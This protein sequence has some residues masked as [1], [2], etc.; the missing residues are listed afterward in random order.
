MFLDTERWHDKRGA[1]QAQPDRNFS[2]E[3]AAALWIEEQTRLKALQSE[4]CRVLP[5]SANVYVSHTAILHLIDSPVTDFPRSL[6][7]SRLHTL[8]RRRGEEGERISRG[9]HVAPPRLE[10]SITCRVLGGYPCGDAQSPPSP[11]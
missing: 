9:H 3:G 10:S 1:C 5:H 6:A 8:T 2:Q 4:F 7:L 11:C